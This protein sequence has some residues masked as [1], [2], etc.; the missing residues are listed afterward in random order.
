MESSPLSC[1]H[2]STVFLKDMLFRLWP[3]QL[4]TL[5]SN[6]KAFAFYLI[7]LR[8]MESNAP[9]KSRWLTS[10][11]LPLS[12]LF[13]TLSKK[14]VML[15]GRKNLCQQSRCCTIINSSSF[16]WLTVLSGRPLSMIFSVI[17]IRLTN[18]Q[19]Q[20]NL[21]RGSQGLV[22]V[23]T[24]TSSRRLLLLQRPVFQPDKRL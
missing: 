18:M 4:F 16:G 6:L 10:I 1:K 7:I 21:C 13:V 20:N 11:P 17:D 2:S 24:S 19:L 5:T 12:I 3:I 23:P 14:P 22:W 9:N 8:S 15:V